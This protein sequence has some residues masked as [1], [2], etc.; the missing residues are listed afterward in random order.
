MSDSRRSRRRRAVILRALAEHGPVSLFTLTGVIGW[1]RLR[2][3]LAEVERLEGE[4]KIFTGHASGPGGTTRT[5]Y[6]A[7]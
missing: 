1:W 4:G 7:R 5:Y 3:V 6:Q 2:P